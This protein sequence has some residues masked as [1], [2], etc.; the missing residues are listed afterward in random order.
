MKILIPVLLVFFLFIL[1]R[2]LANKIHEKVLVLAGNAKSFHLHTFYKFI[3][4]SIISVA[5]VLFTI[6]IIEPP[7][8]L[9]G[10]VLAPIFFILMMAIGLR[11]LLF[12][13]SIDSERLIISSMPGSPKIYSGKNLVRFDVKSYSG[14]NV[15]G[16]VVYILD[17]GQ[18]KKVKI[19]TSM[20]NDDQLLKKWVENYTSNK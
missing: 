18:K 20:L 9:I 19:T 14:N 10:K 6:S 2:T 17:F 7:N 15:G 8:V 13:V 11:Q 12:T 3:A 16:S 5:C 1:E 4:W